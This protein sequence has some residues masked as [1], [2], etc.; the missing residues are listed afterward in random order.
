M[1]LQI[2]DILSASKE[3]ITGSFLTKKQDVIN[4][5]NYDSRNVIISENTL[6][7]AFKGKHYNAHDYINS[8]YLKGIRNFIIEDNSFKFE[9]YKKANIIVVKSSFK[10]L[11]DVA[12]FYKNKYN[13][14]HTIGVTGSNGKTIIKEWLKEIISQQYTTI[15]TPKSYNS[16]L[17][18]PIS[19]FNISDK[20]EIGVFEAGISL[21]NEMKNLEKL[22]KPNIGVFTNL[23]SAHQENFTSNQEK[24]N[25]KAVLFKNSDFVIYPD[26]YKEIKKALNRIN[27]KTE[28]LTWGKKSH[29]YLIVENVKKETYHSVIKALFN[30]KKVELKIPFTD[31]ASIENSI[32]T[33]LVC[34]HISI[35][36]DIIQNSFNHFNN[37]PMRLEKLQGI[38]NNI[39]IN[40]S[41]SFDINALK[42][43]LD[44]TQKQTKKS[45]NIILSDIP[46]P[47]QESYKE[48]IKMTNLYPIDNFIGIG[49][50]LKKHQHLIKSNN[51][52]F[53]KNTND[54]LVDFEN[55]Q[56][57]RSII[58]I[59]GARKYKLEEISAGLEDKAHETWLEINL[60]K[61]LK[62][63]NYFKSTLNPQT[64]I[65]AMVKASSY[66]LGSFEIANF[67]QNNN[68]DYLAVAYTDEGVELRKKGITCPIMVIKPSLHNL[69][70][71]QQYHLE[72]SV[73]DFSVLNSLL[74]TYTK[75]TI[76]IHLKIDTGMHRLGFQ[77]LEITELL[78]IIKNHPSLKVVSI[79]SHLSSADDKNEDDF[80]KSQIDAFKNTSMNI[81]KELG[82]KTIKHIL[83]SAGIQRF[84]QYQ[85]DMVRLGIGLFG[86]GI[87][88]EINKHVKEIASLKSK[89]IQIKNYET[90]TS[91]GYNRKTK[92]KK[93]SIIATIPI[94]YA[95]GLNRLLSNGNGY[96]YVNGKKATIV[97]N[98]CMDICMI[99]ITNIDAK[100][101][102]TVEFFGEHISITSIAK[103]INTI[104]YEIITRISERIKRIYIS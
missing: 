64:K 44:Y 83:N 71:L 77:N 58:L 99:D 26:K 15:A 76:K 75:T 82:Y 69:T 70:L 5:I 90:G 65:M 51:Q 91:I 60:E 2:K 1:L 42:I 97:G 27:P 45:F 48:L 63:Y 8:L 95:D 47:S 24:A 86:I 89:I 85:F 88:K 103:K 10:L 12:L 31:D 78:N 25:E 84:N 55:H 9:N 104:P 4:Y 46:S 29:N 36:E 59:K 101:G 94:G 22:I 100:I 30:H 79:L 23:L 68:I 53:Y 28:H 54:C 56:I 7:I 6:F 52:Y 62:N 16:Q 17:G 14:K 72:P 43:A 3:N 92:L 35:K 18:V 21:S 61:L 32:N 40:D 66:G 20:D 11:H 38:N 37:I 87:D 50:K 57:N 81:E 96:T 74:K 98:I 33:W 13:L 102:D 39:I 19:L 73:Y 67:L 41:Y 80:T 93:P 34:L 49:T